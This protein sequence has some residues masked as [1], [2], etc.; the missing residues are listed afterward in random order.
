[1]GKFLFVLLWAHFDQKGIIYY[2]GTKGGKMKWKNPAEM[3]LV[4]VECSPLM[5]NCDHLYKIFGPKA[6]RLITRP[7]KYACFSFNI[8]PRRCKPTNYMLR[9]YNSFDLECIRC[10]NFEVIFQW[11][12]FFIFDTQILLRFLKSLPVD[13][14]ILGE[15]KI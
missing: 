13:F 15:F 6:C 9:H 11:L 3:R 1:M 7:I 10:W 4:T 12:Y 8:A 5:N 14:Y 2:L